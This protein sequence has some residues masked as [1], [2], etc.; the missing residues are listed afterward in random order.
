MVAHRTFQ[1]SQGKFQ[2]SG[3][4]TSVFDDRVTIMEDQGQQTTSF[5]MTVTI[6]EDQGQK[7]SVT[8]H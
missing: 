1:I 2:D 7:T 3:Q 6:M 8:T 5:P 4:Q